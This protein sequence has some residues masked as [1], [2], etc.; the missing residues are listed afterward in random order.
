MSAIARL[1]V[2]LGHEVSGSDARPSAALDGLQSIGVDVA[3][4]HRAEQIAGA[5]L[6]ARSTA[7][8]DDNPEVL[9]ARQ[10]GIALLSRA[11]LLAA[12][13]ATRRTIAVSGTHGK[14][15]TSAMLALILVEAGWDPSFLVGGD[16]EGVG[17]GAAWSSGPWFVVEADES[18]ATFLRL[19]AEV[20]VVTN[21]EPDHLEHYGGWGQLVDA[22]ETFVAAAPGP[23]IVTADNETAARL[24]AR[25]GAVTFG[26]AE[27]ADYVMVDVELGASAAAFSIKHDGRVLGR[28]TVPTP[29]LHNARNACAAVVTA[30]ALGVPFDAAARGLAGYRGVARRFQHRGERNGVTFIDDYAHLPGEVAA[31]VT[32][33]R[34]GHWRRIV[35][36]FQPHRYSR[37]AALWADFADSFQGAD[38]VA[39]T[40]IYAAGETPRPGVTGKLIVDAVLDAHPEQRVAYLPRR[41]DLLAYLRRILQP[42]DLCL[43]LGAGDVTTVPDELHAGRPA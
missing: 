36:A 18:D 21:I 31:A 30:V 14:T 24:A 10:S 23:R 5:D 38:T 27:R 20:V 13:A 37:T 40:D 12:I 33:A 6:V 41:E 16:I 32:A 2:A 39:I 8:P 26:T 35:V 29:G 15:T 34:A 28:V 4:G 43:T 22:F 11:D 19:G 17:S 7:I 1:L 3:V 25:H 42:G 9:A